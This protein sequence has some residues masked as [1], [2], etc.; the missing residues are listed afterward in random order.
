MTMTA[1]LRY[2]ADGIEVRMPYHP[3]LVR[4]FRQLPRGLRH[5]HKA[6]KAWRFDPSREQWL[7]AT[8]ERHGVAVYWLDEV[9]PVP[10]PWRTLWLL[11]GAPLSV[12]EAAYKALVRLH[13]PDTLPPAQRAAAHETMVKLNHAISAIRAMAREH[14]GKE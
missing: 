1:F 10:E 11:P 13:H 7:L 14:S 2:R 12:A 3:S 8:L 9:P 6:A 4:A 5:W